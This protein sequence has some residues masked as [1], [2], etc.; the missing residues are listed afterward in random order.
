M[1]MHNQAVFVFLKP[2]AAITIPNLHEIHGPVVFA[3]PLCIL[4]PAQRR[5][6]QHRAAGSQHR[7][8]AAVRLAMFI[9]RRRL[10]L[11]HGHDRGRSPPQQF[12]V[13][14]MCGLPTRQALQQ[15]PKLNL[16]S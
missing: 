12:R 4:N 13:L 10:N 2:P 16:L 6:D 7:H 9:R 5:V 11:G 3:G 1:Q 8:H 15:A 14:K